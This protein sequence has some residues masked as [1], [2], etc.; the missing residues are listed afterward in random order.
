MAYLGVEKVGAGVN[1]WLQQDLQALYIIVSSRV[2][3]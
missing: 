3:T 1:I 2:E